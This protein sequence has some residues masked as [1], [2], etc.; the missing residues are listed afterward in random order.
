MIDVP[1]AQLAIVKKIHLKNILKFSLITKINMG[2]QMYPKPNEN[3]VPSNRVILKRNAYEIMMNF[4]RQNPH[5]EIIGVFFGT[6]HPNGDLLIH[7]A[8][9]FRV[10]YTTEV[11]FDD[12]DY[13]RIVPII[14]ECSIRSLEWLG[15]FHSHPFSGD[16]IYMSNVDIA[17]Q[18]IQEQMNSFWTAIVLNPYQINDPKTTNGARAFRLKR[19][20]NKK[21]QKKVQQLELI[22]E[23]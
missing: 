1:L 6:I 5:N 8:Y 22:L 10:G 3:F 18:Y 13:E 17:H 21:I 2:V 11:Q 12:E 7:E 14:K 20:N 9:P 15:W 4:A 23:V 16:A 19:K